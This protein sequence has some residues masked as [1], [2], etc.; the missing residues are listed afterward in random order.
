MMQ[1]IHARS[2]GKVTRRL[3]R[4]RLR[5]SAPF[6]RPRAVRRARPAGHRAAR[7]SRIPPSERGR[8]EH[9]P[10]IRAAIL[11]A[12]LAREEL[13]AREERFPRSRAREREP[14]RSRRLE[15]NQRLQDPVRLRSYHPEGVMRRQMC[16][17]D[18]ILLEE[19]Q[20]PLLPL[21]PTGAESRANRLVGHADS[22]LL[23]A[24]RT[25]SGSPLLALGECPG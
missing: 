9:C 22:P 23:I 2:R 1:M 8:D 10:S 5:S 11:D 7:R 6:R 20:E 25:H 14:G 3:P 15:G 24:P 12:S 13:A 16:Q 17:I 21:A 18:A 4:S 19:A